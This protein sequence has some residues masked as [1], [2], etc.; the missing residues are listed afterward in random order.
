MTRDETAENRLQPGGVWTTSVP[1]TMTSMSVSNEASKSNCKRRLSNFNP[2]APPQRKK[3]CPVEENQFINVDESKKV[4]RTVQESISMQPPDPL[5][6]MDALNACDTD[7]TSA[8][9]VSQRR[10]RRRRENTNT[11]DELWTC[12]RHPSRGQSSW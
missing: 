6:R 12:R 10:R 2:I 5:P 9:A 8:A 3:I 1:L 4:P 7:Q 11:V